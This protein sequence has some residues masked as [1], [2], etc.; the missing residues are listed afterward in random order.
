MSSIKVKVQ[1]ESGQ[2]WILSGRTDEL[3]KQNLGHTERPAADEGAW[4]WALP[5]GEL[6]NHVSPTEWRRTNGERLVAVS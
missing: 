6:V 1:D 4:S 5:N 3:S 2:T